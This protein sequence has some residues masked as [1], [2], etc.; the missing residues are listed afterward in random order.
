MKKDIISNAVN[1]ISDEYIN[2]AVNELYSNPSDNAPKE[3]TR[4]NRKNFYRAAAAI[5]VCVLLGAGGFVYAKGLFN[6]NR[7]EAESNELFSFEYYD[8][9]SGEMQTVVWEDAKYVM[10]FDGPEECNEVEFKENWVPVEPNPGWNVETTSDDGWRTRLTSEYSAGDDGGALA[11]TIE[12]YYASQ[13]KNDGAML[14]LYSTPEEIV[15]EQKDNYNIIKM[16]TKWDEGYG[17]DQDLNIYVMLNEEA[18]YVIVLS[19]ASNLETLEHIA[20]ELEIR[21]T[22]KVINSKDYEKYMVFLEPG[23]G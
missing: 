3:D 23:R 13:F 8:D 10:T 9:V 14:L 1:K 19:G 7:R 6:V 20:N 17:S 22:G 16:R 12:L 15:E 18:G 21:E 4:M 2:E 5:L 11:Y